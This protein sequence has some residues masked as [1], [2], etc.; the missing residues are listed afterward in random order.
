MTAPQ[1]KRRPRS[2]AVR[3]AAAE[4]AVAASRELGEPIDPRLLVFAETPLE[5]LEQLVGNRDETPVKDEADKS[6]AGLDALTLAIFHNRL[7]Q[8]GTAFLAFDSGGAPLFDP[9]YPAP[10]SE[11]RSRRA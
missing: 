7:S 9:L 6:S 8:H 2:L 5:R 3:K 4:A 1:K 11:G 10:E